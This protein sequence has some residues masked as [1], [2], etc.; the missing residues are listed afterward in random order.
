MYSILSRLDRYISLIENFF[1]TIA[2][3]VILFAAS[4]QVL[5]RLLF[6]QSYLW[7]DVLTQNLVLWVAMMGASLATREEKHIRIDA[8]LKLF[9]GKMLHLANLLALLFCLAVGLLL[10]KASYLFVVE[11]MNMGETIGELGNI[12]VWW[13][14]MIMPI[15][16]ACIN[17]RFFLHALKSLLLL[18]GFKV[19]ETNLNT[20]PKL[21]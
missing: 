10:L 6:H 5:G 1:L 13:T 9:K 20:Q 16:F 8:L 7:S 2:T 4:T 12:P 21:H 18:F 19:E 14:V 11:K 15:G 3:M 17:F